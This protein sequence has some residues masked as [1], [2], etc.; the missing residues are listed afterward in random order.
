[1]A[2]PL[3]FQHSAQTIRAYTS[4]VKD[5]KFYDLDPDFQRDF[6]TRH[7]IQGS[8]DRPK[9]TSTKKTFDVI[10]ISEYVSNGYWQRAV[11]M[12]L[13]G[14]SDEDIRPIGLRSSRILLHLH[15]LQSRGR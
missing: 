6:I 15:V 14:R 5:T 7:R 4:D 13:D 2:Q 1:M 8:V 12:R 10:A 3:E 11:A 9:T